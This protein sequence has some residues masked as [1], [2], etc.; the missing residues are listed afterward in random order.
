MSKNCKKIKLFQSICLIFSLLIFSFP[1]AISAQSPTSTPTSTP[2]LPTLAETET[3]VRS[4]FADIPAMIEIAKCESG[5][6]QFTDSGAPLRGH[7]LYIG[8]FQI[9]EKIH[10]KAALSLGF[11]IYTL[12]GNMAYAKYLSSQAGTKP[13]VGCVKNNVSA[14]FKL[15]L[16]LKLGMTNKE[17]ITLQQMLNRAGF[18]ITKS[19]PGSPGSETNY[20]GSLTR[21]ALRRFQCDRGIVCKGT[22]A[23][24]GYGFVGPRTRAALLPAS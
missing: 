13:W 24:T 14:S 16:N 4:Y 3:A 22:E 23:T 17:V 21:A 7:N 18:I 5:F 15:T 1:I 19:G 10:A 9:D 6:R 2:A 8:V 20:F 12:D 11:D